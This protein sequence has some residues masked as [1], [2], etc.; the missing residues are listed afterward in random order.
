VKESCG[1]R[2]GASSSP[3]LILRRRYISEAPLLFLSITFSTSIEIMTTESPMDDVP[4]EVL[5][6]I[7][8]HLDT[9]D[10]AN[11]ALVSRKMCG[12]S[13]KVLYKTVCLGHA[14]QI[15]EFLRTVVKLPDLAAIVRCF[16]FENMGGYLEWVNSSGDLFTEI[17]THRTFDLASLRG[18]IDNIVR[19]K[20]LDESARWTEAFD[21][22]LESAYTAFTLLLLPNLGDLTLQ[23][24][25]E[26]G[27]VELQ[28][29]LG[30]FSP[31][32]AFFGRSVFL[33]QVKHLNIALDVMGCGILHC[34]PKLQALTLY[35]F[36]AGT[37]EGLNHV[38]EIPGSFNLEKL[39]IEMR[40][41]IDD[42]EW[43][44][45]TCLE[46][47]SRMLGSADI[48]QL[49]VEFSTIGHDDEFDDFF[50]LVHA[51][52]PGVRT[53]KIDGW[54]LNLST[55]PREPIPAFANLRDLSVPLAALSGRALENSENGSHMTTTA[56]LETLP[57][58]LETL[59]VHS[60]DDGVIDWLESFAS[61]V[62]EFQSFRLLEISYFSWKQSN[63]LATMIEELKKSYD[64]IGVK[65]TFNQLGW[66]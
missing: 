41:M 64:D 28:G 50:R 53:L 60:C 65:L 66:S 61:I 42:A 59:D 1:L 15:L 7:V 11:L 47:L 26:A 9:E 16:E 32:S 62:S 5:L 58:H 4:N 30:V 48:Q 55:V 27:A 25:G 6:E 40:L 3:S 45:G 57:M 37:F 20:D 19:D 23:S 10:L 54:L 24:Q 13:Q 63:L 44:W 2:Q 38:A 17:T 36:E 33:H 52:W 51:A 49:V 31:T 46:E 35:F 21:D 18:D 39:T 56:L 12:I 8:G 34:C 22:Q 29:F 14:S 43:E